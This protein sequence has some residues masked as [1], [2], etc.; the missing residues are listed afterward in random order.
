[1]ADWDA[2]EDTILVIICQHQCGV[3]LAT[4]SDWKPSAKAAKEACPA[5]GR[6][7]IGEG[8]MGFVAHSGLGVADL[9]RSVRFYCD[10]LGFRSDRELAMTSGQVSDF[11]RLDPP[12]DMQAVYL[13]LG[14]FQ[15]ELLKFDPAGENRVRERRMNQIGLTHISIA[16]DDVP[17]V[18]ARL[19]DY[20]GELVSTI[21]DKA[22]MIR[23]PDG[24]LTE[25]LE[26][27]YAAG[28]RVSGK[29]GETQG[30]D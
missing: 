25:I 9:A 14:D 10:L 20:G 28:E 2:A 7:A 18:L 12:A 5:H 11:L 27:T 26:A 21:G 22:A 16:V 23:D 24:Q 6:P 30:A 19:A 15:L 8:I 17:A 3:C 1:M 29:F 13:Y 4:G